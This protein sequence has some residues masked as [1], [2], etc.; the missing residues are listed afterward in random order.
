[1]IAI[2][3]LTCDRYD[4]TLRTLSSLVEHN[5]LSRFALFHADDASEDPRIVPLAQSYGFQTVVQNPERR[6]WLRTRTALLRQAA[7]DSTWILNLEND[8]ESVRPFP[9]ALFRFVRKNRYISSLRL[10]GRFKDRDKRQACLTRHKRTGMEVDWRPLRNA[11]EMSQI[12]YIHWSA[13]PAVT[14]SSDIVALHRYGMEPS[15][16]TVRVKKNAMVHIG[17]QRTAS[18]EASC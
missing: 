9:W 2:A 16:Y 18:I 8:I 4:Y 14:R 5:D 12:G 15:G 6:G 7:R 17:V 11:P 1:M 3:L 13:Q 10:Y